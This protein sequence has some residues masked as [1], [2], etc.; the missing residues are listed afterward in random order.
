[1]ICCALGYVC[2]VQVGPIAMAR[3]SNEEVFCTRQPTETAD[4]HT[5]RH[6]VETKSL[7]Y[8]S[9]IHTFIIES[10]KLLPHSV[11][12][13][14]PLLPLDFQACRSETS[15]TD[16]NARKKNNKKVICQN[17]T[18]AYYRHVPLPTSSP[19]LPSSSQ[20]SFINAYPTSPSLPT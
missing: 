1:M 16:I 10:I 13:N 19:T 7:H 8:F 11:S 9:S 20:I 15:R 18:R 14:P 17:Q 12:K 2:V 4:S 5:D 6:S 3:G